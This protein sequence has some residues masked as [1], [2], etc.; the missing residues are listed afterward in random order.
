LKVNSVNHFYDLVRPRQRRPRDREAEGLGDL[1]VD[2]QLEL[3]GLLDGQ[4]TR[5]SAL[6]DLVDV[7]R[8]AS[9][10]VTK[11]GT[12]EHETSCIYVL[13][14]P[15][16]RWYSARCCRARDPCSVQKKHRVWQNEK[17]ACM[18]TRQRR[19]CAVELVSRAGLNRLNL[20]PQ[21]SRG[22]VG[23]SHPS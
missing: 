18:V 19:E 13:L 8:S 3:G 7:G 23:L 20:E 5:M 12:I 11:R 16:H 14:Q 2:D 15:V 10:A 6:D 21:R 22:G 9:K 4:V 17:A 1:H